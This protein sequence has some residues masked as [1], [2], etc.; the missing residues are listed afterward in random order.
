MMTDIMEEIYDASFD[1]ELEKLGS[2]SSVKAFKSIFKKPL[3]TPKAS[4]VSEKVV[5]PNLRS[6]ALNMLRLNRQNQ[7]LY[8]K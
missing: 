4:V 5:D 1:N 6:N 8:R 2:Y 7:A 3:S